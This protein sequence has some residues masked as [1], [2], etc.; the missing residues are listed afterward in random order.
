LFKN[1]K[2]ELSVMDNIDKARFVASTFNNEIR[3]AAYGS[4]PLV[5]PG[6][7]TI[8]FHTTVGATSGTINRVRYYLQDGILYKGVTPPTSGT[9]NPANEVITEA[10]SGVTNGTTPVFYYY[11]GN[12]DGNDTNNPPLAQPVNVNDV[13][14]V[15]INLMVSNGANAQDTTSFSINTGSAIRSLKDNLGE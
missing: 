10:L 12:Y 11:N 8:V 13:R 7:S 3:A 4:F 14:F 1:P 6:D 5:T 15:K 9:Y 2:A